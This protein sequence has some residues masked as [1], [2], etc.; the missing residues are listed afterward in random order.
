M[1]PLPN[2]TIRYLMFNINICRCQRS[3]IIL[4]VHS[5]VGLISL[6]MPTDILHPIVV[7]L[8][9]F[10]NIWWMSG[11]P[12]CCCKKDNDQQNDYELQQKLHNLNEI[13]YFFKMELREAFIKKK[14]QKVKIF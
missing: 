2:Q 14:N 8:T 10:G 12:F 11:L 3:F 5:Y 6:R 1:L 13:I 4:H 9:L 7:Q